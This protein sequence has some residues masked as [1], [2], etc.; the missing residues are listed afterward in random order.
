MCMSMYNI[1]C[2]K[3][4][5]EHTSLNNNIEM[6]QARPNNALNSTENVL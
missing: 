3:M 5:N 1:H 6:L 4:C 2:T